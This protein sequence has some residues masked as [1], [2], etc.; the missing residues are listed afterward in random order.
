MLPDK[1]QA[2]GTH[3]ASFS[4]HNNVVYDASHTAYH[5]ILRCID[6]A[7]I[8]I[9]I[10][11]VLGALWTKRTDRVQ[12]TSSRLVHLLLASIGFFVMFRGPLEWRFMPE[13]VWFG[14]V[15]LVST[16]IGIAVAI[17]ARIILGTNW[18]AVVTIKQGHQIIRRG[19]YAVIRHPIYS[20]GLLALLGTA[21]AF[22][23]IR[24]LIGFTLIFIA[25]WMKSRLEE[26]FLEEQF[27]ADY[28][29]Y[30]REVKGLIPFVL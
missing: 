19:P 18:S 14:V 23:E 24:G 12:T 3:C 1:G 21:I 27:G 16:V 6:A 29:R 7:W 8:V 4:G 2:S 13:S 17:W 5:N 10:V 11:W 22:G 15:G 30:K 20:G 26:A 25:W 28:T 9:G